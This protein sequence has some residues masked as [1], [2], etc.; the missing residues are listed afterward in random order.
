MTTKQFNFNLK[1]LEQ[2]SKDIILELYELHGSIKTLETPFDLGEYR[3]NLV[4][5]FNAVIK[6]LKNKLKKHEHNGTR[7]T[8]K[9]NNTKLAKRGG[10][11]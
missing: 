5:K 4:K 10:K 3:Y 1:D 8:K 9:K 7:K 6:N 11:R 2:E